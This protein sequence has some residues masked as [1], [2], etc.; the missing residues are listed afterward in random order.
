MPLQPVELNLAEL[1]IVSKRIEEAVHGLKRAVH[2][3]SEVTDFS[4]GLLCFQEC[5]EFRLYVVVD[6]QLADIVDK[7]KIE[8]IGLEFFHL[9]GEDFLHP[10]EVCRVIS[11]KLCCEIEALSRIVFEYPAHHRL[12]VFAVVSPCGIKIVDAG[13]KG[14]GDHIRGCFFINPAL[15]SVNNGKPHGTE[16]EL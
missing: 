1:H 9:A 4:C 6:V 2:G 7:V 10:A 15:V 12:G 8:I 11:R 14:R 3:K 5:H 13:S 16:A